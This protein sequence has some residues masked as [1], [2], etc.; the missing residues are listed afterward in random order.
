MSASDPLARARHAW[1]KKD[2]AATLVA[3]QPHSASPDPQVRAQAL[4][5]CGQAVHHIG[6]PAEAVRLLRLALAAAPKRAE[7][8]SAIATLM[9]R[10]GSTADAI[11]AWTQAARLAPHTV[12][13]WLALADLHAEADHPQ[14]AAEA[15]HQARLRAPHR[16][17]LAR[18]E[19]EHLRA[20]GQSEAA[21]QRV[22]DAIQRFPTDVDLH[23][24]AA[25]DLSAM[26]RRDDGLAHLDRAV[27]ADPQSV[28]ARSRRANHYIQTRRLDA[29]Q[30]DV[31]V[32]LAREPGNPR[33]RLQQARL[34]LVRRDHDRAATLLEPL[35]ADPTLLGSDNRGQALLYRAEL[36][37]HADDPEG[38]WADL[39]A[40]QAALA[41]AQLAR[42]ED[43]SGYLATVGRRAARLAP[44]GPVV[45]AAR[46]W[47][48]RAPGD[49]ALADRPPVFMFGFPRSGTTLAER[50]LGAHP[51]L[52][53][54]DELNLLGAVFRGIVEDF[55]GTAPEDL[56]E[57]Q[58]RHLRQAFTAKARRAG[59]DPARTR[60]IDK[61][62][63]NFVF[64]DIVRRV[65]PDAPVVMILRDP[66]DCVWSAFR[67]AFEP[68]PA[69]VL[70]RDL[71]GAARL[72]RDT[73]DLWQLGR[74]L[75]GLRLTE[76]HYEHLIA[77]FDTGAR[78]LVAAAGEAWH[79]DVSAFHTHLGHAYVRTPSFAAVGRKVDRTR[80]GRWHRHAERMAT[81]QPLLEPYIQAYGVATVAPEL[82]P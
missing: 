14:R 77:D 22:L 59:F 9:A 80:L 51:A 54:T 12:A 75:P 61:N 45:A 19:V 2:A 55:D 39:C 76:V 15:V 8:W 7:T 20:A 70:T 21:H 34:A 30:A 32:V 23:L 46:T 11:A 13:P 41:E 72:Y 26:G 29:A 4:V 68:N 73:L 52:T 1:M 5:L 24:L 44:N 36:H 48:T 74:Q 58:V 47:P 37:A 16:A 25:E 42:G 49:A 18:R 38:E 82:V 66:R 17:D 71:A 28:V 31:D 10:S 69:L 64:I 33:A 62:P 35:L 79:P 6:R 27:A 3:A 40:G 67:Q 65:F 57:A 43:G 56:T 63:L 60:L 53:A 50:I 78:R 81:V